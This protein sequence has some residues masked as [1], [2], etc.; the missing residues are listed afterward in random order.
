MEYRPKSVFTPGESVILA[1]P[2][3]EGEYSMSL[4]HS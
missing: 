2:M 4:Y 3:Y 1:A